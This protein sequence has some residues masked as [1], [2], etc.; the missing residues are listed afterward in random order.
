MCKAQ[1]QAGADFVGIG[2]AVVSL[3]SPSMYD[4]F[5]LPFEKR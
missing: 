5:V 1:I 4:E 2:D 3:V